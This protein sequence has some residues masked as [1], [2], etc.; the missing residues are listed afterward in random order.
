MMGACIAHLRNASRVS[1]YD[2]RDFTVTFVRRRRA[3]EALATL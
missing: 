3:P 2:W 1:G